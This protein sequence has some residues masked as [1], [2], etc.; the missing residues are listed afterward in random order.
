MKMA[1]APAHARGMILLITLMILLVIGLIASTLARSHRLQ[2]QMAGNEEARIAAI[3]HAYGGVDRIIAE[4]DSFSARF[5]SSETRC[6]LASAFTDCER[7]SLELKPSRASDHSLEA[8]VRG[9]LSLPD[10]VPRA[11]LD[12]ATS[13][14]HFQVAKYEIEVVYRGASEAEGR[15]HITQGV[16]LRL[17][18]S[19]RYAERFR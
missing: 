10:G 6:T 7:A 11:A 18:K 3:Q 8:I 1:S 12:R 17:P 13:A 4:S 5:Q 14:V 16:A 15:A 19:A 9:P 2:L